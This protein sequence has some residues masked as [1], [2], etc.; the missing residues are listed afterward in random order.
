MKE[1]QILT[2]IKHYFNIKELVGPATY[3]KYGDRAWFFF[4]F[5]ALE[6]LLILRK[7]INR[8]ITV[9]NWHRNGN[10]SQRGL[11][12]NI[13]SIVRKKTAKSM[14]YISA[15]IL[16]AAFDFDV[17]GMT[18]EE[19]RNWIVQHQGYFPHK[20]RLEHKKKNVPINW[21]HLDTIFEKK[22]PKIY[23]FNI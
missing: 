12:T 18:A 16:G 1:E 6:T 9:N 23:L 5:R 4:N 13:Q 22:K 15:H 7:N 10:F 8:R 3:Q 14:L 2:E 17:E 19:V 21:V 20:M 11:R